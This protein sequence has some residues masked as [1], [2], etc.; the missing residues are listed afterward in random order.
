MTH[1]VSLS[2]NT[3]GGGVDDVTEV[4]APDDV[5]AQQPDW[6]DAEA[7]GRVRE[8]LAGLPGLVRAAE[9]QQLRSLLAEVAM[10]RIQVIQAG[11]CAE[12]PD[13]CTPAHVE[14]KAALLDVLA[15]VMKLGGNRPVLRVGRIAG[16]FAK[17]RSRPTEWHDGVELPVFRGHMVNSPEPDPQLRQP[18]PSR[19][20][21]G[22]RAAGVAMDTLGRRNAVHRLAM[23]APVWTSHEALLLDYELPMLRRTEEGDLLLSSTHWPWIGERTRQ[24][25]SAH[26]SLLSRV[27][28]PVACKIGPKTT[29]PELLRLCERLDTQ[30]EPG[31]LTLIARMS[32]GLVSDRLPPL[33]AA[34]AEHGYPVIWLCDPLHGNTEVGATGTKIRFVRTAV[35]EAQRF[36]AAVRLGGG[37]A[38]GLHLEATPEQVREC[39]FDESEIGGVCGEPMCDPRLNTEQAV[40]VAEAWRSGETWHPTISFRSR[41]GNA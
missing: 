10:G 22:Y 5:I 1:R 7:L 29:V 27:V 17:P 38:G 14:R 39:V 16:Q 33:V 18:D 41:Y 11:D 34:V 28:N 20:L 26:V 12:D 9:T 8:E 24:D 35:D 15:A 4:V 31:R 13:H 23:E 36:Q 19:I 6:P 21:L 2:E 25:G 40:A 37:T 32:A 3:S 30:R